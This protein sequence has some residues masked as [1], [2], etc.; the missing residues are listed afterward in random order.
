MLAL[1]LILAG[2]PARGDEPTIVYG[3]DRGFEGCLAMHGEAV[4]AEQAADRLFTP[5]SVLKLLVAAAALHHL[6]P[7]HRASTSVLASGPILPDE[8]GS[9]AGRPAGRAPHHAL[10]GDLLVRAAGDPT[11]SA[12]FHADDPRR[13]LRQVVEALRARGVT[14]IDGDLLIDVSAFPGRPSPASRA[15]AEV[16]FGYGAATSAL[17]ID[18]GTLGIEI[19]PGPRI[20]EPPRID[21]PPWA[22]LRVRNLATTV[23]AER[24]G[25]GTVDFQPTWD[26]NTLVVRGEYPISEPPYRIPLAVPDPD[27]HAGRALVALLAEAGIEL[28]GELRLS[29]TP[30]PVRGDS[31][32]PLVELRSAPLR[33]WLEAILADSHNWTAEMLSRQLALVVHGEGRDELGLELLSDLLVKTVGVPANT[34][35]LDDASGLSPYDLLS[36]RTTV[37]LLRWAQRQSWGPLFADALASAGHGTLGAWPPLPTGTRAKTGT[38]RNALGLAGYVPLGA[39][40]ASAGEPL[41]FACFLSHRPDERPVLRRELASRVHGFVRAAK[42]ANRP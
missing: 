29:R 19:A 13:P 4:I 10:H 30:V 34:F 17:A 37:E 21:V 2:P 40:R 5:A 18:E 15:I 35:H 3:P 22:G 7:D 32:T 23:G 42:A 6:G 28:T 26:G 41:V 14:R 8:R 12:R 20:G 36:P 25:K 1:L 9:A 31:A 27:R 33:Q 38:L 16:A 11:W 39:G 24:D